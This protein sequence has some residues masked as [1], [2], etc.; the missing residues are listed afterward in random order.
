MTQD[1]KAP[2]T[3]ADIND[4]LLAAVHKDLLDAPSPE[5]TKDVVQNAL[6][7]QG[8]PKWLHGKQYAKTFVGKVLDALRRR[9]LVT[10]EG[11]TWI[12]QYPLEVA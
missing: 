12:A 6:I 3:E 11:K 1:E 9:E 8:F 10:K 5:I 7:K 2:L 4:D